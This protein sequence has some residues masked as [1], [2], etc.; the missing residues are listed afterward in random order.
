MI[1]TASMEE[2]TR[3]PSYHPSPV[4]L[5]W[6]LDEDSKLSWQDQEKDAKEACSLL[7]SHD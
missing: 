5:R 4:L 2:V 6:L 3:K 1:F 7:S